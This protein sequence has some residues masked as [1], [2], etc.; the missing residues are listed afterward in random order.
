LP[1]LG[2]P[3]LS[4][5]ELDA[6]PDVLLTA[7]QGLHQVSVLQDFERL[8]ECLEFLGLREGPPRAVRFS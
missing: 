4:R 1:A 8:F 5:R 6:F 7:L 2:D 3:V